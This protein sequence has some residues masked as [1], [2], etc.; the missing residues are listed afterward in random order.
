[1]KHRVFGILSVAILILG[2]LSLTNKFSEAAEA[3]IEKILSSKETYHGKEVSVS[4]KVSGF[5]QKTSKIG[6]PYT[7][8]S[9]VGDSGAILNIYFQGHTQVDEGKSAKV[10]GIYR[11]EK[12]VGEYTFENEIEAT[13]IKQE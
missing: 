2:I 9:L 1:M 11:K 3:T 13:D 4:G 5:R 10:T 6:N 7:T 12:R 8:F